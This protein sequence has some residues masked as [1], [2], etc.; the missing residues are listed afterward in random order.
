PQ[1]QGTAY[2]ADEKLRLEVSGDK[3]TA[4]VSAILPWNEKVHL[5]ASTQNPQR[6]FAIVEPPAAWQGRALQ[7]TYLLTDRAHNRTVI[8]VDLEK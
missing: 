6:F 2:S 3:D 5:A 1:G 7:V 4:R 8:T